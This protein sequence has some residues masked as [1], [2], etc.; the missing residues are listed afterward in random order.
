MS[1]ET[2]AMRALVTDA[3]KHAVVRLVPVPQPGPHEIRIKVHSIALNPVDALYA[4]HQVDKPGRVVGSDVAG[5]V[6]QAGDSVARWKVGDRVA[7]LLQG[8]T[9][10]NPRP[11]GFATYALLEEDLAI[12]IP[13]D[14]SFDEAATIPLC[15]LTAAQALFIRLEIPSPFPT[16]PA[17][18]FP[19]PNKT[20]PP[21]ILIY[22]GATSLGL[23][24]I[25]LAK[26]LRTPIG[27]PYN[28][29]TTSSPKNFDKLRKLGADKVYDYRD[30]A[31]P[32]QVKKDLSGGGIDYAVDCIKAPESGRKRIAVIRKVAWNKERVR[33]DVT[34]LYGAVWA[35]L[36]HEVVYNSETMPTS[37]EWRALTVDF[38]QWLS[39]GS[40]GN[41]R[42]KFP[43]EPNPVRL[44][45]GGLERV[46]IDGFY[47]LGG[48]DIHGR[49][50]GE[51]NQEDHLKP[52]S[53][54]K[55][56]YR[57]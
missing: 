33:E 52:I 21:T 29:I 1:N 36:G 48:G 18:T 25:Q 44:M 3:E 17:L 42:V 55:L 12:R 34:P 5:T 9:S 8:A 53:G 15:A 41:P 16:I 31:W 45:P 50:Q 26:L 23:F 19:P 38:F 47:L 11:G 10:G 13:D 54:E 46:S 20:S 49:D 57:L 51:A 39:Y 35:G 40:P 22:S 30:P 14:V 7:G 56:V 27:E 43:I 32:D 4:I 6:D 24:T 37:P 28:V 2:Q